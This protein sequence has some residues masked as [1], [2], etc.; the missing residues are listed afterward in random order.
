[1][2]NVYLYLSLAGWLWFA[3]AG[4]YLTMRL[5]ARRAENQKVLPVVQSSAEAKQPNEQ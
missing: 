1:M 4:T 3:V 5:R 2:T